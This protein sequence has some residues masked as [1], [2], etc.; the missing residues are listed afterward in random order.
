MRTQARYFSVGIALLIFSGLSSGT[1]F[2]AP[3]KKNDAK[4]LPKPWK[5][6]VA[7]IKNFAKQK[8]YR[9]TFSVN[10]GLSFTDDHSLRQTIVRLNYEASIHAAG[11]LPLMAVRSPRAFRTYKKGAILDSGIWR[12]ISY[13]MR[14]QKMDR[15]FRFP[16]KLLARALKYAKNA[17]WLEDEDEGKDDGKKKRE[18]KKKKKSGK[19]KG[20]TVVAK[21]SS[22]D[23]PT[24]LPRFIGV[25][26]PPKEAL[27]HFVEVE[28]SGCFGGG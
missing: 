14:G 24:V 7:A 11:K 6:L 2:S 3:P 15:L 27:Q 17:T 19:S 8:S 21:R 16:D 12:G 5:H 22:K 18:K 1:A 10:G 4:N 13:D 28:S 23:T 9:V 25:E 20:R 26:V